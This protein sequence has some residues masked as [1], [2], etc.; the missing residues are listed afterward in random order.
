MLAPKPAAILAALAPTT[1]PPRIVMWAGATP[2][3][4]PS[5]MPAAHLRAFEV[6]GPLLDAHP[7]GHFAHGRQQRQPARGRRA[8]VS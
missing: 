7:A 4:P 3:T 2:G 5:R 6:L 8:S 1:P